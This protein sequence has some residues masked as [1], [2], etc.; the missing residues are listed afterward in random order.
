MHIMDLAENSIRAGAD[1]VEIELIHDPKAK[2]LYISVRD[3]GKGVNTEKIPLLLDPFYT[4]KE[5]KRVGLGIPLFYET[6][7]RCGGGVSIKP[8]GEK[9]LFIEGRLNTDNID[10]P[11]IGDLA[12]AIVG[13]MFLYP[14]V[15]I[16]LFLSLGN[17]TLK[18]SNGELNKVGDMWDPKSL[19]DLKGRIREFLERT[20]REVS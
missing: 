1:T 8:N 18:V 17:S 15:A 4:T 7:K 20:L 2:E 6:C 11:P 3:N 16:S 9:G 5:G 13:L 19:L 14:S 12:S 10:T